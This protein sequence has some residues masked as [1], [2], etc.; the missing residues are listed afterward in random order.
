MN[1]LI[2]LHTFEPQDV[3]L[4]ER[5]LRARLQARWLHPWACL[6]VAIT[7]PWR[8]ADLWPGAPER[9]IWTSTFTLPEGGL[10]TADGELAAAERDTLARRR[11]PVTA[12]ELLAPAFAA[13]LAVWHSDAGRSVFVSLWRDRR[14]RHSLRLE[15]GVQSVRCDGERVLIEAPPRH[16]PEGDRTGVLLGGWQRFLGEPLRME[17]ASRLMFVD[18]LAALTGDS[19]DEVLIARG[20]WS[21]EP[22]RAVAGK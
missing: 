18:T 10:L 8:P 21:S 2:Q 15:P 17:G 20:E 22:A 1:D 3:A 5:E 11:A 4:L 7:G 14:L 13:G 6:E 16:L 9:L 12:A 19:P